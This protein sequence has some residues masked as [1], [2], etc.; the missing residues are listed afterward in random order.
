MPGKIE[1]CICQVSLILIYFLSNHNNFKHICNLL[2]GLYIMECVS[3]L[4]CREPTRAP[5]L[6]I[7]TG[8][9]SFC[10]N[11]VNSGYIAMS[12]TIKFRIKSKHLLHR[13]NHTVFDYDKY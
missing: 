4:W 8:P 9:L 12:V 10:Q 1:Y 11:T 6:D 13:G 5:G 2:C 7:I 3:Q